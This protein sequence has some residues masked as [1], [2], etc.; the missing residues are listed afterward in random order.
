MWKPFLLGGV[1]ETHPN[2]TVLALRAAIALGDLPAASKALYAAYWARALD[3][4]RPEVV[5]ATLDGAG[6]DGA[7]IVRRAEEPALKEDLRR[8][9]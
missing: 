5:A 1:P 6:L 4:S 9:T 7:A 8:R 2:R 3:V